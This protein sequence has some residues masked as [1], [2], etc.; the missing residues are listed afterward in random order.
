M[1]SVIFN[2]LAELELDEGFQRYEDESAGLGF[3]FLSEV[4]NGLDLLQRYPSIAQR[5]R[6]GIRRLVLPKF[7]YYV[8]YRFLRSGGIRVLAVAHQK[9][10]PEYWIGRR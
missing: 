9:R 6:S 4:E 1:R 2:R 10:R 8:V 3:R 5:A 7:P